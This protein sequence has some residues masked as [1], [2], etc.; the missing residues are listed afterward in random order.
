MV[1]IILAWSFAPN[2]EPLKSD[3]QQLEAAL[4]A[5]GHA[6]QPFQLPAV[7]SPALALRTI[8]SHRLIRID[9]AADQLIC[10]GGLAAILRHSRK[11]ACFTRNDDLA[12]GSSDGETAYAAKVIRS[13]ISES[14]QIFVASATIAKGL[15]ALDVG[16][17]GVLPKAAAGADRWAPVLGVLAA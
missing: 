12:V 2:G 1:K 4:I 14:Y 9:P 8:A 13:A 10:L 6:V 3:A 16:S 15:R 7:A 11:I 17:V 5:A